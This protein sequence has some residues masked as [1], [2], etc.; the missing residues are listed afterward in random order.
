MADVQ[1]TIP[2]ARVEVSGMR[3]MPMIAIGF[4]V[5]ALVTSI[6]AA[7]VVATRDPAPAAQAGRGATVTPGEQR[8]PATEVARL[9]REVVAKALDDSGKVIGVRVTDDEIRK[10]LGLEPDDVIA[11]ISGRAIK[12]EFDVYDAV[13]GMSMMDASTVYVDIVR[14]KQSLLLRWRLDGNLRDA[15]R[16]SSGLLARPRSTGL[17]SLGGNPYRNPDPLPDP[18]AARDPI[19]ALLD[20]VRQIDDLHYEVPRA[21][22]VAALASQTSSNR[23]LRSMPSSTGIKLYAVR[24]NTVW[25]KLGFQNGDQVRSI[26]GDE[27]SSL[28]QMIEAFEK[29][30]SGDELTF[31]LLRAAGDAEELKI[32][33]K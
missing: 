25:S 23:G 10:A 4:A 11:A 15:R 31:R 24:S 12:R 3:R 8:V 28:D 30:T 14:G 22:I 9:K 7:I 2:H 16:D 6:V 20:T 5:A 27:P 1:D 19:A 13:L 32:T 33:I 17:G 26:N 21:T 29:A 18:F